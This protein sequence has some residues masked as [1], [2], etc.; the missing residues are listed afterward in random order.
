MD[1]IVP[2]VDFIVGT[3]YEDLPA[4]LTDAV[5]RC[6]LASLGAM[7]AGSTARGSKEIVDMVTEWGGKPEATIAVYGQRVPG[8]NALWANAAMTRARELD[9]YDTVASDH[10]TVATNPTALAV[11]ELIGGVSGK[12]AITAIVLG[13]DLVMRL[14]AA[15]HRRTGVSPW[16]TGAWSVFPAAAV[17]GKLMGLDKSRMLDAMGLAF[18]KMSNTAQNQRE[19]ALAM[20]VHHGLGVSLG[21]VA[22]L[23]A[24]KGING[25][26]E[27]LEGKFGLY[28]AYEQNQ[29]DRNVLLD[30]LGQ[31]YYITEL[32]YKPYPCC[33][34]T[35]ASI[36]GIL[37]LVEKHDIRPENVK[38]IVA[39]VPQS[40][41]ELVCFPEE[42]RK[43]PETRVAA[44]FSIP[45]TVATAVVHRKVNMSHFTDE[46][47]KEPGVLELAGRVKCMVDTGLVPEPVRG[48]LPA[49]FPNI[50]EIQ[51]LDG[52]LY[53]TRID[54]VKGHHKNPMTWE[55]LVEGFRM[56]LTMAAKPLPRA[57]EI[58]DL[59]SHLEE[60]DDISKLVALLAAP[61]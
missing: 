8:H 49:D 16:N 14:R 45:Y 53:S 38:E 22:V 11:A 7:V 61:E 34:F 46:A 26:H 10:S 19:G 57:E 27:V 36:Y 13:T 18:G 24:E 58:I 4:E 54:Y 23:M 50:V 56:G 47:R 5:K 9:P 1:A 40:Y 2:L 15:C 30:G 51:T 25:P 37:Q 43:K 12:D 60:V 39:R 17:A 35:H 33:A 55:E 48:V 3:K 44:Q 6:L 21:L 41:Y 31:E 59:I 29:Y 42:I 28:P 52:K 20:C 32:T